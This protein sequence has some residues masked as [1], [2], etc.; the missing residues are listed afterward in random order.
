MPKS[1]PIRPDD[2]RQKSTLVSPTIPINA[3]ESDPATEVQ[4]YGQASLVRMY[5]DMALIR[6][7]YIGIV[8]KNPEQFGEIRLK[9]Q[10]E[11]PASQ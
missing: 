1:I 2:V 10:D 3:Y 4:C 11:A 6:D 7:F 9:A 5:H 8:G